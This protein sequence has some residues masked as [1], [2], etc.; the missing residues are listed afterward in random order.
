MLC[1]ITILFVMYYN[2][3]VCYVPD[4][5]VLLLQAFQ[6]SLLGI[7]VKYILPN[8]VAPPCTLDLWTHN[9]IRSDIECSVGGREAKGRRKEGRV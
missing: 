4:N 8:I 7:V 9:H 3:T 1:T 6:V 5:A 2:N